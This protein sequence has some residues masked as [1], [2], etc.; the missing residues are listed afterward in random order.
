M[1]KNRP[2]ELQHKEYT[3][4][5]LPVEMTDVEKINR[6]KELAVAL[7]EVSFLE[8][9]KK[10]DASSYS[11]RIKDAQCN[12]REIQ[13]EVESGLQDR[14]VKCELCWCLTSKTLITYRL[15]TG[16]EVSSRPMTSREIEDILQLHLK[17]TVV[18]EK[19]KVV[20]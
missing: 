11:R 2:A 3:D 16:A 13:R 10:F 5:S 7:S 6:G 4:R 8:E 9:K 17:L 1:S 20:G 14:E 12:V 19:E 15:D 18:E